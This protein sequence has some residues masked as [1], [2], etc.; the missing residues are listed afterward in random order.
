MYIM[1]SYIPKITTYLNFCNSDQA[2]PGA[3]LHNPPFTTYITHHYRHTQKYGYARVHVGVCNIY[4]NI[5]IQQGSRQGSNANCTLPHFGLRVLIAQL[6]S[7]LL[8]LRNES[9]KR[10]KRE[11]W[12]VRVQ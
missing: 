4:K 7:S 5:C 1:R 6:R 3:L 12:N 10:L 8:L 11:A 9:V 2:A